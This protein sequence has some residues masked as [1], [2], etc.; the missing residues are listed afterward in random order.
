MRKLLLILLTTGLV[1]SSSGT[2]TM[3]WPGSAYFNFSSGAKSYDYVT[4][5]R[6]NPESYDIALEPWNKPGWCTNFIDMGDVPLDSLA[7]PP[8]SGYNDDIKGYIDCVDVQQG[9]SYWVKTRDGKYAKLKV[10]EAKY[11]GNDPEYGHM[12]RVRFEWIYLG[13][14]TEGGGNNG[15]SNLSLCPSSVALILLLGA[16]LLV[17]I[18]GLACN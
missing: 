2:T 8:A 3:Q 5:H 9:H 12:N 13:N 7:T 1:F 10:A 11:L 6:E 16:T 4:S 17:C 14:G 18:N 15:G